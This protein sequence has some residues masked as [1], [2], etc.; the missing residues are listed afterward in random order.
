MSDLHLDPQCFCNGDMQV[1]WPFQRES[2][3]INHTGGAIIQQNNCKC[4]ELLNCTV[5]QPLEKHVRRIA[6]LSCR[7]MMQQNAKGLELFISF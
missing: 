2:R 6:V 4:E 7:A 5:K 1:E 3:Q